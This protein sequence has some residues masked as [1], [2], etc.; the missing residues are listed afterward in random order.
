MFGWFKKGKSPVKPTGSSGTTLSPDLTK[1]TIYGAQSIG[2]LDLYGRPAYVDPVGV[3]KP[4]WIGPVGINPTYQKPC[5]IYSLAEM[6]RGCST[7]S[8]GVRMFLSRCDHVDWTIQGVGSDKLYKK[9][10]EKYL[11]KMDMSLSKFASKAAEYKFNGSC[12]MEIE[13][14][15][16]DGV[17]YPKALHD[18][19]LQTIKKWET[20]LNGRLLSIV[21]EHKD[22]P[23][24]KQTISG[25]KLFHIKESSLSSAPWGSGLVRDLQDDFRGYIRVKN[26]NLLALHNDARGTPVA[27]VPMKSMME[28]HSEE[29]VNKSIEGIKDFLGNRERSEVHGLVLDSSVYINPDTNQPSSVNKWDIELLGGTA[30]AFSD[31]R[32]TI[33]DYRSCI[34]RSLGID[35]LLLGG[36]G[37]S[38]ALADSKM[39][40]F[41]DN[42]GKV[43]DNVY[44]EFRQQVLLEMFRLNGWPLDKC[45]FVSRGAV[46][47]MTPGEISAVLANIQFIQ[48]EDPAYDFI[49]S[50]CGVPVPDKPLPEVDPV[51]GGTPKKPNNQSKK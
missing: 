49:R 51:T 41:Y 6:M 3:T 35:S 17:Y 34:A 13:W 25:I 28:Q 43:L 15:L 32:S 14:G 39:S 33:E 12:V 8:L 19:P 18:R 2:E 29:Y 1:S 44:N 45:P 50:I 22:L 47:S 21:Q 9:R 42:V 37:G 38:Y 46:N 11:S 26:D 16:E 4:G 36:G 48:Q 23:G 30:T 5:K 10:V 24:G 40:N 27:R 7:I 20:D 31:F